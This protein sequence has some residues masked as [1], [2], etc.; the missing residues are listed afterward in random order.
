LG[1]NVSLA[2]R[3][4]VVFGVGFWCVTT[5]AASDWTLARS[6]HS[7]VYSQAGE[8]G[9]RSMAVLI[10]RLDTFFSRLT[11]ALDHRP[12][13]RVIVFRSAE[14]YESY[15]L[16]PSTGAYYLGSGVRDFIVMP[17]SGPRDPHVAAHEYWHL[18]ARKSD[19]RLPL[20]LEEGLAE[21]FANIRLDERD[22]EGAAELASRFRTLHGHAWVPL[23]DLLVLAKDSP[24]RDDRQA[25]SLFYMQSWALTEMLLS[26][27]AYSARFP[28]FLT[29]VASGTPSEG[30]LVSLY[31]KPLAVIG[32]DL[33]AWVEQRKVTP[34]T[35]PDAEPDTARVEVVEL[36]PTASGVV[37]ADLLATAGKSDR[38]E[39]L[40][41]E[42]AKQAPD[43]PIVAAGLAMLV[44]QKGDNEAARQLLRRSVDEGL[45]DDD[46]LY[47]LALL[48]NNA[49]EHES[50]LKDLR[51]M[52][53]VGPE[54]EFAYWAAMA[55]GANQLGRREEAEAAAENA[56]THASS[57]TERAHAAELQVIARTD[58]VVQVTRDA[59]GQMRLVNTRVPHGSPDWN[60]FVEPGDQVR[61]VEGKL[62]AIDCG[63]ETVFAVETPA[64][65]VRLTI[66]DPLH[67]QMR[68]G[69][70]EYTCGPQPARD[71]SVV[72]AASGPAGGVLRGLEF[73]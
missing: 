39:S 16:N 2:T 29:A 60:P 20:W 21:F 4:L 3:P 17:A 61:R 56:L 19:L 8:A 12:P 14:E 73:H 10:A 54:R 31:T 52:G 1:K 9:A 46:A 6:A 58:V 65:M 68:N 40:Y 27:P 26:D 7:E 41:R 64:G 5:L 33:R 35:L 55:Y 69:P 11:P 44:L 43:D 59:N 72:Y 71:V 15:R 34:A 32:A 30:A 22:T 66:P 28:E 70:S 53:R 50:A 51:A 36:S 24:L 25:A 38:A 57:A 37:L 63:A 45:H 47:N 62:R 49:G 23:G 48:E 13:V 18:V 67:V 42:L